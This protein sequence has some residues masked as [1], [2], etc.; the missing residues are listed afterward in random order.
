MPIDKIVKLIIIT[1][2]VVLA[3]LLDIHYIYPALGNSPLSYLFDFIIS[4]TEVVLL[5]K[6]V[7]DWFK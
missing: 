7:S 1:V 3:V 5:L 2:L 6:L 4:L